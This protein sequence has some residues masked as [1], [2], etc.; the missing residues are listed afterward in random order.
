MA[1]NCYI[2]V[3]VERSLWK[4]MVRLSA[5][6]GLTLSKASK[7][8]IND[9]AKTA[10]TNLEQ[11]PHTLLRIRSRWK[12]TLTLPMNCV[13]ILTEHCVYLTYVD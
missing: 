11:P 4:E 10:V 7:I 6:Y 3:S 1:W 12:I 5:D 13:A 9:I 2:L 8:R